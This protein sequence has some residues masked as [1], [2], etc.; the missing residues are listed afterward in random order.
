MRM[1]FFG[2]S[3]VSRKI[4]IEQSANSDSPELQKRLDRIGSNYSRLE[5]ILSELEQ[6][7]ELDDRL[8][9]WTSADVAPKKPR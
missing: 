4:R 6:K 9:E 1:A 3:T 8:A 7:F 2:K 5:D